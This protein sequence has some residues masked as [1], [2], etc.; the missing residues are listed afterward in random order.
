[1]QVRTRALL[2][3]E[4]LLEFRHRNWIPLPML[5]FVATRRRFFNLL[6]GTGCALLLGIAYYLQYVEGME[7]CPLCIFQRVVFMALAVVFLLAALHHPR[8]VG[9]RVYGGTMLLIAGIGIA[10]AGRHLWL[11]SLPPDQVPLCGPGLSY[12]LD[13][14]PLHEVVRNVLTGSGECA[15][16]DLILG[17]SIPVWSLTGFAILGLFGLLLNWR[18]AS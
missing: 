18:R 9:S 16:V 7:P 3:N 10:I 14:F 8:S 2:S 12:M 17:V 6:A 15:E 4:D 5:D 11:Q 13:V 1:M